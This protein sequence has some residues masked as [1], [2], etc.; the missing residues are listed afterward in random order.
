MDE[1][2]VKFVL[3]SSKHALQQHVKPHRVAREGNKIEALL[4]L[5]AKVALRR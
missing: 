5:T 2:V 4:A 1:L 3:P